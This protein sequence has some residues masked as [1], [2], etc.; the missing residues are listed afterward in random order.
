MKVEIL[1]ADSMGVRSLATFVEM[2]GLAIAVD[3]GAS[4]APR[5]Y[6]LPP[7]EVE[8]EELERRLDLIRRRLGEAQIA[9]ITHYH[10]DHYMAGEPEL[11]YGKTVF[12]KHPKEFINVSQRIR[13]HRFLVRGG[14]SE[15]AD[16][17]VADGMTYEVEGVRIRFSPP[18]WHGEPGTKVGRVVMVALEC[19]EG[20][21]VFGSDVQGPVDDEALEW[22]IGIKKP[23]VVIID[24]PPTYFAGYKV[25]VEAVRRGLE[26]L[27][28]LIRV[29]K[30]RVVVVDH[31]MA[32]DR[33]VEEIL[34]SVR[35][36]SGGDAVLAATFMGREPRLL[37]A[38]RRELWSGGG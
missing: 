22:L 16:V 19:D 4:L 30:P 10:Y 15:R 38:F 14:V 29:V 11:Y 36:K 28:T 31:H 18:V 7:H 20:T 12:V 37:E 2:C 9:I 24:G 34:A 5:R 33:R 23:D 35:E 27:A 6:G 17:R 13:A 3:L 8:V 32:R 26:N 1:A 25:P 21:V